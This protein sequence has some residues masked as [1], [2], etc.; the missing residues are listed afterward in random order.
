MKINKFVV[1][2]CIIFVAALSIVSFLTELR[3]DLRAAD[4]AEAPAV[5]HDAGADIADTYLFLDPANTNNVVMLM[6]IHGFIAP[7]ENVNIGFFDPEVRYRFEL[8]RTG[9]AKVDDTIDI[10]FALRT[11]S[12]IG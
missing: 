4:H 7:Q 6:T 2:G 1:G 8:E 12:S 11:S 5:A 3:L 10:Q 9:D